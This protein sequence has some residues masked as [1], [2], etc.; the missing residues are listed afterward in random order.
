MGPMLDGKPLDERKTALLVKV[1]QLYYEDNLSQE[2]IAKSIKLSRPY[3]SRLLTEAKEMGIIQ[4]KVVDPL[5]GE[6]DLERSLRM[7]TKLEK[8]IVSPILQNA[9]RM[10]SLSGKAVDYLEEVVHDGDVLGFGWGTTIYSVTN[11]LGQGRKYPNIVAAQLCGG[12]SNLEHNI[13]CIE[14]ARNFSKA[15]GAKPYVLTCPAIVSSPRLKEAFLSDYNINK[16]MSYGYESNIALITMGT[17]G[18]QSSLYRSGY[19]NEKEIAALMEKGA[20]G[21]ICTHV[22]DADGNIC[23][24]ELDERTMSVPLDVIK[25]KKTRIGVACGQSKVDSILASIKAEIVNVLI[26]DEQ[27]AG[28]VLERLS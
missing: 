27:T 5:K 28:Y 12:I 25:K 1:A 21:D 11:L 23:D 13:Y 17:F 20:V 26:T 2:E 8:V 14:I 24:P 22:I 4:F 19:L 18:L 7:K 15:W 3:V 10:H 16:V 6:T 9:S